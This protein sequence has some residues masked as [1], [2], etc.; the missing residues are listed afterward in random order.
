MPSTKMG[1]S[2]VG[3]DSGLHLGLAT[4]DAHSAQSGDVGCQ[5][6]Y[7]SFSLQNNTWSI[8]PH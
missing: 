5:V 2:R 7:I 6:G 3:M 1:K 4:S 8:S